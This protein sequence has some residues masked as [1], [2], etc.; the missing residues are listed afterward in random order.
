M[1]IAQGWFTFGNVITF[2]VMTILAAWIVNNLKI[3]NYHMV[4][5]I[6]A[7]WVLFG[8]AKFVIGW[9]L[10]VLVPIIAIAAIIAVVL[11]MQKTAEGKKVS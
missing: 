3:P 6:P 7:V 9:T 2:I 10:A 5:I 8:I 4:W 11:Q 1:I